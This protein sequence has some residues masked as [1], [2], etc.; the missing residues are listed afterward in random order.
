MAV[1][2]LAATFCAVRSV[3]V[4]SWVF[5]SC[6]LKEPWET[7]DDMLQETVVEVFCAMVP[8][9]GDETVVLAFARVLALKYMKRLLRLTSSHR[10]KPRTVTLWAERLTAKWR[11]WPVTTS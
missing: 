2:R 9:F 10:P 8:P 6:T 7:M 5:L 1:E 4:P 3:T 11:A